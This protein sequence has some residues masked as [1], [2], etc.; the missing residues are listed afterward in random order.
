MKK[1]FLY[2]LGL[3][4]ILEMQVQTTGCANIVPPQGGF[5]DS[6][7]PVLLKATPPDSSRNFAGNRLSFSF[8]E[9]VQVENFS[10]NVMVSPIPRNPPT[11]TNKLNTVAV[12]LRDTL[13]PNTTYTIDFGSAIKDVNEGNLMKNFTYVFSTGPY[14]DSL[15]FGGN[16]LMAESGEI[17]STLVVILHTSPEDSAVIQQRPRYMSKLDGKGNFLF[18]NIPPA[19]FYVYALKDDGRI[20]RYNNKQP[21]AFADSPVVVQQNTPRKQ[22]YAYTEVKPTQQTTGG[23]T[24]NV[25]DK[26][27]KFQTTVNN[28]VHDLLKKFSFQFDRPLL[29]FDS[30]RVHFSTDTLYT[31]VGGH[32][33]SIDS[34]KKIATLTYPWRENTLYNIIIEKDFATDTLGQQL[35]KADTVSF[36]TKKNADYG[37]LSIRFRNLDLSK[38]P[39]LQFVQSDA[40]VN[41]FPLTSAAFSQALFLPGEYQLRILHDTNKNGVWDPGEFFGKHK[42]PEIVTPIERKINVKEDWDN[43]FEI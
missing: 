27:L 34:T 19:T 31:P 17:D 24:A 18:R 26:R 40:V 6:L 29:R 11:A 21:F 3:F 16:V 13:Q 25:R 35:L 33:W 43:E 12:R 39:V 9:Y 8:D 10:Q 42:Q 41:S 20:F 28:G 4:L 1:L 2:I 22:L 14:I 37:K 32:V 15:T 23:A 5:R 36:I 7:P 30:S 38:N